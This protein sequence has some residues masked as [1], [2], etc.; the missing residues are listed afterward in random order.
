MINKKSKP[1]PKP[2]AKKQNKT[3]QKS[4]QHEYGTIRCDAIQTKNVEMRNTDT[5]TH[6]SLIKHEDQNKNTLK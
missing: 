2:K 1:K 5:H 6:L 4:K 3:K